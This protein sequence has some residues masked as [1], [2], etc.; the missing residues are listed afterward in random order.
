MSIIDKPIVKTLMLKGEKGDPGDLDSTAIVDNLTT[1]R[2]DKVL[3]AK[4]GKVL[5]DLVDTNTSNIST[6]AENISTNATNISNETN[7]RQSADTTLQNNINSEATARANADV[8]LQSQISGLASG[9]PLV[10]NNVAGMTD[11]SRVYVNTSDGKWYYY[12]DTQWVAGGIYQS[13]E[14]D[15]GSITPEKTNFMKKVSILNPELCLIN[16]I[17]KMSGWNNDITNDENVDNGNGYCTSQVFEC[18][19]GEKYIFNCSTSGNSIFMAKSDKAVYTQVTV[20]KNTVWTVPQDIKYFRLVFTINNNPNWKNEYKLIKGKSLNDTLLYGQNGIINFV[21]DTIIVPEGY[22]YSEDEAII[23]LNFDGWNQHTFDVIA[24]YLKE[25]NISFTLF[26]TGYDRATGINP[27]DLKNY[28]QEMGKK[29]EFALYTGQPSSTMQG[30]T[31][32]AEQFSQIKNCYDG[33]VN[34]GLPRPKVCSFAGG[35]YT[36]LTEYLCKNILGLKIGRSTENSRIINEVTNNFVIPCSGYGDDGVYTI[37]V[38]DTIVNNLQHRA[39]MTHN[40]LSDEV[41]D[42]SYNMRESYLKAWIDKIATAVNNGTLKAMT[43]SEYY[44]YTILPHSAIIGQHALVT[45]N[46]NRQHEYIF[47]DNGWVE[48]TNYKNY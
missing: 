18:N 20:A 28:M 3:S 16:K 21:N 8:T 45:E 29:F 4:Q 1:N 37:S 47:T 40:I 26:F 48:V 38:V 30:T 5:K 10:A 19:P 7:A 23:L 12:N 15:D 9:S 43:F 22:S 17:C 24:P 44:L 31:N 25:K 36:E 42:T 35:Q 2:A 11:T 6:N 41:T 46:D 33:I 39:V 34:Y 14:I 32:F 27:N 13:T